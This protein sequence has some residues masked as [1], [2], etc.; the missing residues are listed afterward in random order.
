MK[1]F[2]FYRLF[3]K[4]H[5][6][7]SFFDAN[8]GILKENAADK[9]MKKTEEGRKDM[10]LIL[11]ERLISWFDSFNIYYES[12]E[13]CFKV[14]GKLAW[15]HKLVIY[16]ASGREVAMI[17]EKIVDILPQF[18]LFKNGKKVGTIKKKLTILRPKFRIDF[19]G[20]D[21]DGNWME[22]D[23]TI[24]SKKGKKVA[25]IYKKLLRLTDTYVIELEHET[26]A[27]DALMVVL[28]IDAEKCSE[29]KKEEKKD[30]KKRKA[31]AKAVKMQ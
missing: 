6:A 11:K 24:R 16:D 1:R 27:L 25:A 13:I 9:R 23:Y 4:Y 10:K 31:E 2:Q 14:K 15:G 18:N 17:R 20:W 3:R 28:A 19:N 7:D 29:R 26:D 22:W 5:P 30:A 21:I 12:G 8:Y